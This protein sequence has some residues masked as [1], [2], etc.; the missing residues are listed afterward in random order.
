MRPAPLCDQG[1]HTAENEKE[2]AAAPPTTVLVPLPK[3]HLGPVSGP[4]KPDVQTRAQGPQP[5]VWQGVCSSAPRMSLPSPLP[6]KNL[7]DK[8]DSAQVPPSASACLGKAVASAFCSPTGLVS[9]PTWT[10]CAW[11]AWP[12]SIPGG[13]V[14]RSHPV[15]GAIPGT[16]HSM[17]G[18][19]EAQRS[20]RY[21][22]RQN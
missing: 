22:I 13:F 1:E 7:F 21:A 8:Q 3:P 15:P 20:C 19:H 10:D 9:Q 18:A 11:Q 16:S 5:A 2:R 4:E 6:V 17:E 12:R 14:Y